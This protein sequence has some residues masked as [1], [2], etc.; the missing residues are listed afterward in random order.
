MS[1]FDDLEEIMSLGSY[2]KEMSRLKKLMS[3]L[4]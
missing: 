4:F 2:R 1:E 3:F